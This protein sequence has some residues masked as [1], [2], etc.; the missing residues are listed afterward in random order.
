MDF[1]YAIDA[2]FRKYFT[3]GGRAVRFEFWCWVLFT[4]FAYLALSILEFIYFGAYF[5][6]K[7]FGDGSI[8]SIFLFLVTLPSF[9]VACR[10]LHDTG[11]SGWWIGGAILAFYIFVGSFAYAELTIG[12]GN[13]TRLSLMVSLLLLSVLAYLVLLVIF[14]CQKSQYGPNKYGENPKNEDNDFS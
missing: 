9:S 4:I 14:W 3:F 12:S 7:N 10:R 5:G 11:R 2:C 1:I 13:F 8:G 6:A